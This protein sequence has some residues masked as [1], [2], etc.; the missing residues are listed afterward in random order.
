[1]PK[2][3]SSLQLPHRSPRPPKSMPPGRR[4]R[5]ELVD[6]LKAQRDKIQEICNISGVVGVSIAVIDSGENIF[7]HNVGYRNLA[8]KEPVTSDTVFHIASMTK[9]F[10]GVCI[11]RLRAEGKLKLDDLVQKHLPKVK[12]RDPVTTTVTIAD[13]LGHRTG[14]QRADNIWLGSEGEV[15]IN[16]DQTTA[17]FRHL[18]PQ[19]SLRSRFLYNNVCYATLGEIILEL[20]GKPYHTYLK[21]N[22]LDPLNMTRTIVT[23][24]GGLPGNSSLAYSTL[25]NNEPYNVP[26][27]GSSAITAMGSA[28]GLL[29]TAKDLSKYYKALM[30]SWRREE[31]AERSGCGTEEKKP[32]IDDVSWLFAPLQIM[33]TPAFREKS[34]AAGWARSQLPTT[35]GDIGVNPGLVDKMPVLADGITNSRLALWHQG[36][37]VGV[38][39]FVMMLPETESAVVV[40]TNT[41]AKNDAADWIGQLLIETLLDS[42]VRHDYVHLA[43]KS[44][45]RAQEKFAEVNRRVQ[46][47]RKP[48]GPIRAL[49]D[50]VGSFTGIGGV[51]CIEVKESKRGLEIL[52]QG[53]ESQ[54]Y[55]LQH[56][57]HDTFT[58]F[59]GWNEQIKKGRF[60]VFQPAFYMIRFGGEDGQGITSLN[61]AYDA[62][63]PE[64]E[65]FVK[66]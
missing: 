42:P 25:D 9:S 41:M 48:G 49:S 46:E 20:S 53:R 4:L 12:N 2:T 34:Y 61:W 59:M 16:K 57:H 36:S 50:Y 28:G 45:D 60:V 63:M 29:S 23:K 64:G 54:K 52:F 31:Q 30:R 21:E 5:P 19:A 10:T 14:L 15:L 38:T 3:S 13:L 11:H 35:V 65:D 51:F 26:L 22:V 17:V 55:Q 6:T 47:G 7:Q 44:V 62:A 27:P 37:L 40:L 32:M 58:W 8:K 66:E 18:R 43:S 56:H 39:S 33:E 24:D 1:M